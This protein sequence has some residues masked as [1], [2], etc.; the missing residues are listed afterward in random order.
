M[1]RRLP[2]VKQLRYLVALEETR[3]FGRAAEHCFVS[4]SAFSTAIKE[5]ETTLEVQLVDRTNRS[6]TLTDSGR[7]F[8]IRARR[9]LQELEAMADAVRADGEPLSGSLKLG[10]IPTIAP[11]LLPRLMSHLKQHYPQLQLYIREEQTQRLYHELM[12]GE[13]DLLL[14]ALPWKLDQAQT[15]VLFQDRFCLAYRA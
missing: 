14:L 6:V 3:H 10:V 2:S 11:F 13:L 9:L 12:R 8:V 5:L 1:K 4:Q 15:E 7:Q